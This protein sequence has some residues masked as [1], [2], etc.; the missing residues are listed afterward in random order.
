MEPKTKAVTAGIAKSLALLLVTLA[1][2]GL[3]LNIRRT[4]EQTQAVRAD[5]E[6][7]RQQLAELEAQN[8]LLRQLRLCLAPTPWPQP[9][10]ADPICGD[11]SAL[12]T[13]SPEVHEHGK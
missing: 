13:P 4:M 7:K 2:V 11:P 8:R 10:P 1:I 9:N 12:A 6:H 3:A 5:S